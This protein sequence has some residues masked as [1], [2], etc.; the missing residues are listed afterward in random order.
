MFF[1]GENEY[2]PRA[3]N[4]GSTFSDTN[5]FECRSCNRPDIFFYILDEYSGNTALKQLFHFDN[6]AFERQL[7]QRGFYVVKQSRSNYN[8]T[9]FSV[10]SILT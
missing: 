6:S 2:L 9:P 3:E 5:L 7:E 4:Q 1:G 8:Y 10:A